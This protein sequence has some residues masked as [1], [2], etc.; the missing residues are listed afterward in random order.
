MREGAAP[1]G[2]GARHVRQAL[3]QVSFAGREPS[4]EP[5]VILAHFLFLWSVIGEPTWKGTT[6]HIE[7][8]PSARGMNLAGLERTPR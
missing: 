6:Y 4:M 5:S 2:P 1:K 8:F 7:T 3:F